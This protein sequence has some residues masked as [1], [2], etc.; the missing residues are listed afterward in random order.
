MTARLYITCYRDMA[1]DST[2]Q[3]VAAPMAPPIA[4]A[5]VDIGP[6]SSASHPLPP[7]TH[8]VCLRADIDCAIA[9]GDDPTADPDYHI[10]EP[11]ERLFYGV[12]EGMKIA[13]IG[14]APDASELPHEEGSQQ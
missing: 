4:E 5:Y 7:Y 12:R 13:V 14:V 8:F 3:P 1:R 10:I 6:E 9:F 11:G 2:N